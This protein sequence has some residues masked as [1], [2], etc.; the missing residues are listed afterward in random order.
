MASLEAGAVAPALGCGT[1]RE[2]VEETRHEFAVD[3]LTAILDRQ[4]EM[5]VAPGRADGD[6]WLAV[7][8]RV[9]DEVREHAVERH[10]IHDRMKIRRNRNSHRLEPT[11][12]E[13]ADQLLDPRTEPK[14]FRG[15][16]DPCQIEAGEVEQLLDQLSHA[17]RLF[18]KRA[19]QRETI[20]L[21]QCLASLGNRHADPVDARQRVAELVRGKRDEL[22][23]QRVEVLKLLANDRAVEERGSDHADRCEGIQLRLVGLRRSATAA[24]EE[25]QTASVADQR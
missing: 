17:R 22:A 1:T 20:G 16:V 5:G 14:A 18:S 6:R 24:G 12:P 3:A 2:P 9:R 15:H 25:A 10:R 13:P 8:Q 4:T 19:L 7:L 23:L 21:G 11:T